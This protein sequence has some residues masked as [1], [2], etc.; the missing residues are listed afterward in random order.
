MSNTLQISYKNLLYIVRNIFNNSKDPS[1]TR[2]SREG[3]FYLNSDEAFERA[4]G[5]LEKR[6]GD[7][8]LIAE[9]FRSKF[10]HF[11]RITTKDSFLLR[12]YADLLQQ[13][14]TASGKIKDLEIL[15]DCRENRKLLTRLTDWLIQRWGRLVEERK[16]RY[17]SFREF[18]RFVT[19]EADIACNPF[20]SFSLSY[21]PKQDTRNRQDRHYAK[22]RTLV[23]DTQKGL[24]N[25]NTTPRTHDHTSD[26]FCQFCKRTKHDLKVC[27]NFSQKTPIERREFFM[28]N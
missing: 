14:L 20:T 13:C 27:I 8:F 19:K 23:N 2:T 11:P 9:A 4:I 5:L 24:Q 28:K 7:P 12:K 10:K 3:T 16:P 25:S 22:G 6:Y 18:T 21:S 26:L 17:P 1:I 15:N